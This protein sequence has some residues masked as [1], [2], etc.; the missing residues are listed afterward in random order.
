MR[1]LGVLLMF[2]CCSLQAQINLPE[3]NDPFAPMVATCE[4]TTPANATTQLLWRTNVKGVPHGDKFFIWGPPGKHWL[5]VTVVTSTYRELLVLVPDPSAPN[6]ISKAKTEKVRVAIGTDVV[7]YNKDFTIVGTPP[8]PGPGPLPGPEPPTPPGPGPLPGP[9]PPT[10]PGP[11]PGPSPDGFAGEVRTWLQALPAGAYTK[12]LANDIA[13]NY[14]A[15][16]AQ[17]VATSGWNLQAFTTKTKDLNH[18]KLTTEQLATWAEPFFRPLA[19]KQAKLFQ[20]RNLTPS[21]VAGIAKLWR[22]TA[23]AI[24]AGAY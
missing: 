1:G 2:V 7:R 23:E 13:D 5:E 14:D 8:N 11:G 16:A 19:A 12:Q 17:A 6:D 20:E 22:D 18:Q 9:Q 4:I 15:T 3:E 24:R 10:P 21:D